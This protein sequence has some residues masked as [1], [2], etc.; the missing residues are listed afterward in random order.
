MRL[1][2]KGRAKPKSAFMKLQRHSQGVNVFVRE[3]KVVADHVENIRP[4]ALPHSGI[5]PE[6]DGRPSFLACVEL[7]GPAP[8][9]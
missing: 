8:E 6:M 5:G 4:Q 3:G 7:D 9:Q 1:P 2:H